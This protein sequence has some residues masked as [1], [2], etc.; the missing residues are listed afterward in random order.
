MAKKRD[1][2]SE[3][4]FVIDVDDCSPEHAPINT[5]GAINTEEVD[6]ADAS[7]AGD[8][9]TAANTSTAA[10]SDVSQPVSELVSR[11]HVDALVLPTVPAVPSNCSIPNI[12]SHGF[13]VYGHRPVI[14]RPLHV[15]IT[16]PHTVSDAVRLSVSKTV[17]SVLPKGP[18][19][20]FQDTNVVSAL[21]GPS[22]TVSDAAVAGNLHPSNNQPAN[23][24]GLDPMN[25]TIEEYA[26]KNGGTYPASM[27]FRNFG[28][29]EWN[30]PSPFDSPAE[31]ST[32][33][34][35]EAQPT[36][37]AC[38]VPPTD[39]PNEVEAAE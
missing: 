1:V 36:Q 4:N 39:A 38:P 32:D 8:D 34:G 26:A 22:T 6:H 14:S 37:T 25:I 18:L 7:R 5:V 27:L 24:E 30:W 15:P 23:A 31:T 2:R 29:P 21:G 11:V 3:T 19:S 28:E 20:A 33:H 12:A 10:P 16:V 35:N 17:D 13:Q 9:Y